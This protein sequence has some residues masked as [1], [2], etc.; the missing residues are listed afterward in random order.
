MVGNLD[1][2]CSK[3]NG[4]TATSL[5]S[6]G[7]CSFHH[8]PRRR[9]SDAKVPCLHNRSRLVF[10]NSHRLQT[11]GVLHIDGLNVAVQLLLGT[12]LVVTLTRDA[13]AKSEWDT[14]DTALPDLLVELGVETDVLGTLSNTRQFLSTF[15]SAEI[16]THHLLVRKRLDLLDG[17]GGSLLEGYAMDL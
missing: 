4:L 7:F 9:L 14:L 17:P 16:Q 2:I 6:L 12:V 5:S 13:N 10:F 1:L 3:L 15:L 8:L 11:F